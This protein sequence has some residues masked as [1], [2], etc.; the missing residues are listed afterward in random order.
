MRKTIDRP[1]PEA[2]LHHHDLRKSKSRLKILS[3]LVANERAISLSTLARKLK[4]ANKASLFK[5]L[6]TLETAGII[7]RVP[8]SRGI[9]HFA[10]DTMEPGE[11]KSKMHWHFYCRQCK[12]LHTLKSETAQSPVVSV[13]FKA[14]RYV[15]CLYGTCAKCSMT[16][17]TNPN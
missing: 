15:Y 13:G 9:A 5:T 16:S 17:T 2:I 6:R 1:D 7:Y 3:V 11:G 14:A 12:K 10:I 8:V 4:G